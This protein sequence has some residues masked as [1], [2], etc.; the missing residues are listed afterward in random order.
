MPIRVGVD[1]RVADLARDLKAAGDSLAA[2]QL[3]DVLL[4]GA[5]QIATAAAPIMGY[6]Q[7]S[8]P[9]SSGAE[10]PRIA[11]SYIAT[12]AGQS[13]AVATTHPG[14]PVWEFGGQIAPA[15]GPG[16][17]TAARASGHPGE[18]LRIPRKGPA[19]LAA[20]SQIEA[21]TANVTRHVDQ[22]LADHDL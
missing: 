4:Q 20:L 1:D 3:R 11:D 2:G 12:A 9:K 10:L 5:Q 17:V 7:P 19:E 14:G 13:A 8:W 21:V 22:V 15:A 16:G 6:G 18:V